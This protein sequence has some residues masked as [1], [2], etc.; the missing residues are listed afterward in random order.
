MRNGDINIKCEIQGNAD[1]YARN[2]E[3][4]EMHGMLRNGDRYALKDEARKGEQYI[5]IKHLIESYFKTW[6]SS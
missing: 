2:D 6:I 1:R 5:L 3:I 4:D